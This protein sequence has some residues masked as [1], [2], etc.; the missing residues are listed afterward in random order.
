MAEFPNF[1]LN[2]NSV[3]L[4]GGNPNGLFPL[5]PI[6]DIPNSP[7][8]MFNDMMEETN[9][10]NDMQFTNLANNNNNNMIMNFMN[11]ININTQLAP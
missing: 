2:N 7:T 3:M 11:P 9:I 6:I 8:M 4:Q 10:M 1:D 5:P